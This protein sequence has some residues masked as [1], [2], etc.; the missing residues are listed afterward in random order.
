MDVHTKLEAE[1]AKFLHYEACISFVS[2]WSANNGVFAALLSP[3][4]A[5]TVQAVTEREFD[6]EM[7]TEQAAPEFTT[8]KEDVLA[9]FENATSIEDLKDKW[10]FAVDNGFGDNQEVKDGYLDVMG[11]LK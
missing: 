11:K 1:M 5:M 2:C 7:P 4:D 3:E 6:F 8:S 9:A 10:K